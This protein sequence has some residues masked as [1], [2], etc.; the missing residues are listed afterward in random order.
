MRGWGNGDQ[1]QGGAGQAEP[2]PVCGDG[3]AV[4]GSLTDA[5]MSALTAALQDEHNARALYEQAIADLGSVQPFAQIVRAEER[6][7]ATLERVFTRH[8]L[9]I[10]AV[11][12]ETVD[13]AYATQAEACAAALT[14]EQANVALYDE[15][16]AQTEN[17]ELTRVFTRLQSAS[18]NRHIPALEACGP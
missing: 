6:H 11:E 1:G 7:I 18:Q 12:A 16:F 2:C 15:L 14:A 3:T 8:G 9:D 13:A 10:P 17:A 5:E 4:A